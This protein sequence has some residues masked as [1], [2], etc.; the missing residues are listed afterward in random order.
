MIA[1]KKGVQLEPEKQQEK[2][3]AK[4]K[5]I[6]YI[7]KYSYDPFKSSPNDYPEHELPLTAGEYMFILSEDDEDGFFMGQLLSG[8]KG[9]VPSNFVERITLD[10]NNALKTL[11]TLPTSE[12]KLFVKFQ[13]IHIF[14]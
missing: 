1:I 14:E 5:Y 12:N 2:I 3:Q 11:Q 7:C 6:L 9:L 8:R 4:Q 13:S 10:Q